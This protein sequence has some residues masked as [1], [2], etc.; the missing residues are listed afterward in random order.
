MRDALG[1]FVATVTVGH[2]KQ[3]LS[4]FHL[5]G[6]SSMSERVSEGPETEEDGDRE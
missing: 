2:Y 5:R 6:G 4:F 3:W 1:L